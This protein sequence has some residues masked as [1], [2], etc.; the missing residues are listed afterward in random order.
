[1]MCQRIPGMSVLLYVAGCHGK[2]DVERFHR[3]SFT[4]SAVAGRQPLN[5]TVHPIRAC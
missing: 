3:A 1:M 4:A 2:E 5:V